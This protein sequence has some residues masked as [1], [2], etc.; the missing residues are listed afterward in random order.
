MTVRR[1][2]ALLTCSAVGVIAIIGATFIHEFGLSESASL[3]RASV[4]H[5]F[6]AVYP[7]RR[8]RARLALEWAKPAREA[9]EAARRGDFKP[10]GIGGIG[11]FFPGLESNEAL[12]ER[13]MKQHGYRFIN[14]TSDYAADEEQARYQHA[15]YEY[16][17]QYNLRLQT[18]VAARAPN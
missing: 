7:E 5:A 10:V 2:F 13:L 14:G 11:L 4:I 15:A 3:G 16:A 6:R 12:A 1:V 9:E 17:K 18:L 8:V